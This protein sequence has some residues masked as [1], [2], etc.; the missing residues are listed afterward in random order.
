M[1]NKVFIL[2]LFIIQFSY[3]QSN[4]EYDEKI[5]DNHSRC[6]IL[7]APFMINELIEIYKKDSLIIKRIFNREAHNRT[8]YTLYCYNVVADFFYKRLL[9]YRKSKNK[10]IIDK[11]ISDLNYN[12]NIVKPKI[13][14]AHVFE[15]CLTCAFGEYPDDRF[16]YFQFSIMFMGEQEIKEMISDENGEQW[17]YALMAIKGGDSFTL[18]KEENYARYVLDRRTARYIIERWKDSKLKEVQD[19]IAVYKRVM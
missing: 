10:A 5:V 12:K 19:L 4:G 7:E 16:F 3:C 6:G 1:K 8:E 2:F 14:W 15:T 11:M 18:T 9:E 17:R 13:D